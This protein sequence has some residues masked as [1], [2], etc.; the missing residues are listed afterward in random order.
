MRILIADDNS[1]VRSGIADILTDNA[2]EVCG[3]AF[4][5]ADALQKAHDLNPDL[6][7]LDVSMPG[8]NGLEI[9][10]VMREELPEIKILVVSQHDL[11]HLLGSAQKACVDGFID[12]NNLG[13]D[14]LPA[15]SKLFAH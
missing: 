8:T 2:M 9:A 12:K 14:L 6:V 7:L 4:N 10:R 1:S 5:G 11:N 3:E 13:T 15:I